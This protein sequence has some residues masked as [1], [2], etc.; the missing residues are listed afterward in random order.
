MRRGHH[1]HVSGKHGGGKDSNNGRAYTFNAK[2]A[3]LRV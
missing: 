3:G 2:G 1:R